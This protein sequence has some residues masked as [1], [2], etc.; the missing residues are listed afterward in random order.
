MKVYLM[1]QRGWLSSVS[2]DPL[3]ELEDLI[4]NTC[5]GT[6]LAPRARPIFEKAVSFGSPV[7]QR[8][9]KGVVRRTVGPFERLTLPPK[10]GPE[11]LISVG[12]AGYDLEIVTA[13]P[14]YR[15]RFDLIAGYV[16]DA[17]G[18]YPELARN[19]DRVFVPLP[20]E[21]G[22]WKKRLGVEAKLLPFG[23]DALCEG[24]SEADRPID[25]LSYG[26]IP[27]RY[28]D[29]FSAAFNAPKSRRLFLRME[30]RAPRSFAHEPLHRPADHADVRL[31]YRLLRRSKTS[32][33]FDTLYPG[34]RRFPYSFVTLR[35]FDAFATGC[36]VVGKRPGTPEADRLM[37]WPDA[38]LEL[39]DD[40]GSA[41][42][43]LETLFDDDARLERIRL[44]N[45]FEALTH[46]DWRLRVRDI[47]S[48]F[49]LEL[50]TGLAGELGQLAERAEVAKQ[51][52]KAAGAL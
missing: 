43:M 1:S 12:I 48:D 21:L 44:R 32:L 8:I 10:T 16:F 19:F 45:H 37:P 31:L 7:Q 9:L 50:P 26:R 17:W 51:K 52:A 5:G 38:T 14:D 30:A 11:L 47:F 29:A 25:L 23:V 20:N 13:A 34:M 41:V 24:G 49:G 6:I 18:A 22:E 36:A 35:W 39:P 46:H 2:H 28:R 40:P 15:R 33:C 3:Y 27:A 4:A 42:D